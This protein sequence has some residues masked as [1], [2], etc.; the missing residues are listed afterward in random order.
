M[1]DQKS[2]GADNRPPIEPIRFPVVLCG[3]VILHSKRFVDS[4][5]KA[6]GL[7]VIRCSE[8]SAG[9]FAVCQRL[10][11]SLLIAKQE[12][13][14]QLTKADILRLTSHGGA[15]HILALL[16]TNGLE[17]SMRML[18]LGCRGV[19]PPRFSPKQLGRAVLAIRDG[20]LWAPRRAV[21]SLLLELL[22]G[23]SISK[24]ENG[25]T[26]QE[27]RILELSVQGY[28][29]SA[30]AS[31][32]FISIET[33]RWHKRRLY[34]KIGKSGVPKFSQSEA[35]SPRSNLAAG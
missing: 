31:A 11:A 26:P 4:L 15:T 16:E 14:Q 2:K 25:L 8:D 9:I 10:N 12:F 32:L 3:D 27:Q 29:N 23:N 30:I 34:R 24:D 20:E 18:Q 7:T 1:I 17:M 33:V 28:K 35:A 19:L 6:I 21:S 13:I 22:Q 5:S